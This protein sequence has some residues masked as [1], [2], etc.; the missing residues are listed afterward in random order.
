MR[1]PGFAKKSL[2]QNFL[3]AP[4]VSE[5]AV[6]AGE[7]GPGD[8]ILEI[9]PGKGA[10]TKKLLEKAG[11][12]IALEKDHR[13]IPILQETFAN[14]ISS[15]KLILSESDALE[16]K[17]QDFGLTKNSY[18]VI[19]NIPYYI[20]G[21]LTEKF[22]SEENYPSLIIF[23]VQKEVAERIVANNKKESI[24]SLSVKAYGTPEYIATVSRGC[25]TP[26]PNVDSALIKIGNISH[27]F[28]VGFEQNFFF[29]VIKA[30]FL[31]KRKRLI[32][33]LAEIIPSIKNQTAEL[34]SNTG[35]G[36]NERAED[37]PL[38]TWKKICSFL[39]TI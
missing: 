34:I 22:T 21:A 27:D 3:N 9:G 2:G 1:I 15:R 39:N 29:T 11:R 13:L 37:V 5:K 18:K 16:F 17:P 31:H 6:L 26:Q 4:W 10:L 28:F 8:T 19:A 30:A 35:I 33:N 32:A 38:Q 25:F 14:E 12:V 7:V 20:T 24:L 36:E 23:L